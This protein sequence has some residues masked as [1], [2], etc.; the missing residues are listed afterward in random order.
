MMRV[1]NISGKIIIIIIIIVIIIIII[2]KKQ[3]RVIK[4]VIRIECSKQLPSYSM[5]K[6]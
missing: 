1:F 4:K 3:L 6:L 2:K 5:S